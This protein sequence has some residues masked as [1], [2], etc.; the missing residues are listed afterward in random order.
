M[1]PMEKG[2]R[3]PL[4]LV[5]VDLRGFEPLTSSMPRKPSR[6]GVFPPER[7]TPAG[8]R[9]M[10][11]I[12]GFPAVVT[13]YVSGDAHT[14]TIEGFWSL[15]KRGISGVYHGVSTKHLQSCV[16]EYVFRYNHRDAEGRGM[17]GA[18]MNRIEKEPRGY[19]GR[20]SGSERRAPDP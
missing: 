3:G 7:A 5:W 17:F 6:A 15:L 12:A 2:P 13:L 9:R 19:W 10:E 16:D 14:N 8:T 20:P 18:F 1:T 11:A 4:G